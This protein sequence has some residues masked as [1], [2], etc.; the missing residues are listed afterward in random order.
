MSAAKTRRRVRASAQPRPA[1]SSS[2]LRTLST[3]DWATA[4]PI[5]RGWPCAH[6]RFGC[7]SRSGTRA[8]RALCQRFFVWYSDVHRHGGLGLTTASDV[9]YGHAGAVR[10]QRPSSC[11][12]PMPHTQSGS[13]ASHPN[14]RRPRRIWGLTHG[15]SRLPVGAP[16]TAHQNRSP[17]TT[18]PIPGNLRPTARPSGLS[19]PERLTSMVAVP[20]R[21]GTALV[22]NRPLLPWAGLL[23]KR[24][25]LPGH[26]LPLAHRQS[27]HRDLSAADAPQR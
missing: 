4:G 21:G 9:H 20:A 13:S 14:R 26:C 19:L 22:Q 16:S 10:Q 1:M 15:A 23:V 24:R 27:H 25:D 11:R 8:A 3:V 2:M 18:L 6:A 17:T 5:G 12:R 7:G